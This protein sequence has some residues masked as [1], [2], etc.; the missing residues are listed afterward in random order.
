MIWSITLCSGTFEFSRVEVKEKSILYEII[1]KLQI[2]IKKIEIFIAAV[3]FLYKSH[4]VKWWKTKA[5]I[6]K[7]IVREKKK[8]LLIDVL[9]SQGNS[10]VCSKILEPKI[11]G[12]QSHRTLSPESKSA[13]ATRSLSLL[14]K[15]LLSVIFLRCTMIFRLFFPIQLDN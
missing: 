8:I 6:L 4:L 3:R 13:I 9:S 2:I 12:P 10:T 14:S 5:K 1:Y 11:F 15:P 7:N